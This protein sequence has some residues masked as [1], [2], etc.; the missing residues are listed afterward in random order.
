MKTV[1][2][3]I[4]GAQLLAAVLAFGAEKTP[5]DYVDPWIES[6]KSRYFF[7]NTATVGLQEPA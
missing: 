3:L 1:W 7:F 6:T 5:A 2:N 4:V